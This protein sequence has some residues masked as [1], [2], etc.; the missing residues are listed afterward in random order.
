MGYINT[1]IAVTDDCPL[2]AGEMPSSRG[3]KK[4]IAMLEL[5]ANS[6]YQLTQEGILFATWLMQRE[7]AGDILGDDRAALRERFFA[8]PKA[9]LR[10]SPQPKK[11]GWG[12]LFDDQGAP[13]SPHMESAAYQQAVTGQL[14]GLTG[15]KALHSRKA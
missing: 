15:L 1:L 10:T 4:T 7:L 9:C 12:L 5:L 6:P 13:P 3:A 2:T 14:A 11:Q 8:T